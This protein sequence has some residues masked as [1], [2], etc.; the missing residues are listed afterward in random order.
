[1]KFCVKCREELPDKATFCSA[2]GE[3]QDY[4]AQEGILEKSVEE[5][6]MDANAVEPEEVSEP[7]TDKTQ[8]V[9]D[10][11]SSTRKDVLIGAVVVAVL[12]LALFIGQYNKT[13]SQGTGGPQISQEEQAVNSAPDRP[14]IRLTDMLR[15]YYQNKIGFK[16]KYNQQV[17]TIECR[18]IDIRE[19]SDDKNVLIA[20]IYPTMDESIHGSFRGQFRNPSGE[21]RRILEDYN[22]S[23]TIILK[24]F[25]FVNSEG[26]VYIDYAKILPR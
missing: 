3:K 15:L 19:A 18:F 2:C 8:K 13:G 16:Q 7:G 14:V 9:A 24:G 25:C 26:Y 23:R 5:S 10:N 1:M 21:Q 6:S 17:V 20:E 22:N 4:K 12:M 11:K